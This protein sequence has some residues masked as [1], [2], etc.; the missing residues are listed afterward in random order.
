MKTIDRLSA[1]KKIVVSN[2]NECMN[3]VV[4]QMKVYWLNDFNGST[5]TEKKKRHSLWFGENGHRVCMCEC[6]RRTNRYPE[7]REK[8]LEIEIE[9]FRAEKI[10]TICIGIWT[11]VCV[12]ERARSRDNCDCKIDLA[13]KVCG[14]WKNWAYVTGG[15]DTWRAWERTDTKYKNG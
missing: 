13:N 12:C 11:S 14:E 7:E 6:A 5:N 2:V 1:K 4:F 8:T 3:N 10:F 9:F 15:K